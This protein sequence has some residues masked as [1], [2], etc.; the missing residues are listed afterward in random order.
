MFFQTLWRGPN[1][2]NAQ[3]NATT[4]GNS[5]MANNYVSES[6]TSVVSKTELTFHATKNIHISL[7]LIMNNYNAPGPVINSQPG[8]DKLRNNMDSILSLGFSF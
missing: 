2:V 1:A 5:A 8:K 7:G 3:S 4:V 6:Y